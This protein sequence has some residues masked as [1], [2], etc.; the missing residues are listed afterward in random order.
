MVMMANGY[1]SLRAGACFFPY[2]TKSI[3]EKTNQ[4]QE[5]EQEHLYT[6]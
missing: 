6:K 5:M 2:R 4:K 1:N 3:V